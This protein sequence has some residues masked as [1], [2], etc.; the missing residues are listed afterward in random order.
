MC[1]VFSMP[2]LKRPHCRSAGK[3]ERDTKLKSQ[4][5]SSRT[6]PCL[7]RRTPTAKIRWSA[8][9]TLPWRLS[10]NSQ[11]TQPPMKALKREPV[12]SQYNIT[13]S[14]HILGV[15]NTDS[16]SYC[17][18]IFRTN[19]TTVEGDT[20][21]VINK[22]DNIGVLGSYINQA[23]ATVTGIAAAATKSLTATVHEANKASP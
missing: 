2:R 8:W 13:S 7:Q 6:S 18:N 17:D 14:S 5:G 23:G 3:R 15:I 10:S 11:T 19:S 21:K 16:H 4:H 9:Q 20:S 12:H 1:I 22:D